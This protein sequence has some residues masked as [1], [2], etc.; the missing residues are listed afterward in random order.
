MTRIDYSQLIIEKL[1][2]HEIPK[3]KKDEVGS[4]CYSENESTI[5]DGLKT[6]FQDKVKS[7]L[8]SDQAFKVCF[9][10][11]T[12]SSVPNCVRNLLESDDDFIN[13][14]KNIATNLFEVQKG[15]NSAG[16]LLI[17]KG[18]IA[19]H[20][21]CVILKLERDNGAQLVLDPMTRTFNVEEV[22]DLMLTRK[23]K[24]FKVALIVSRDNF[25]VDYDG[26][27]MDYQINIKDK[28]GTNSFFLDF[29][30]C[31]PY[32]D[33][34]IATKN[35]YN[36]TRDFI[37]SIPDVLTRA[38]YI[39]DLNSYLQMNQNTISPREFAENYMICTDHK[40]Q[41]QQFLLS[42]SFA[43]ETYTKDNTLINARVKKILLQFENG[44]SIFEQSGS[45]EGKVDLQRNEE[46]GICTA[47][48]NSR[49]K[50][51]K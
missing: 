25:S 16:I 7:A 47:I 36:Y 27:L 48:I 46:T 18:L 3:R 13:L 37:D 5:T 39:Q 45:L 17:I 28:K 6:F 30:G 50:K 33:P 20:H 43:F 10:D 38:K 49:I 1:I 22:T 11:E 2:I 35:F 40:N 12:L 51:I 15:C 29:M 26:M 9:R 23:T 14:S 41:Y 44:V 24:V 34:K 32:N 8:N 4:P 19:I 31:F 42:E 21:V